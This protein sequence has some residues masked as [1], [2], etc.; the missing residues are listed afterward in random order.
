MNVRQNILNLIGLNS[1]SIKCIT[2][3]L[4]NVQRV[5]DNGM[6]RIIITKELIINLPI[7]FTP[8]DWRNFRISIGYDANIVVGTMWL[9]DG[10]IA[11]IDYDSDNL[12]KQDGF[13]LLNIPTFPFE[14]LDHSKDSADIEAF[15]WGDSKKK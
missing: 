11:T 13:K 1:N 4:S 7:N 6:P 12:N 8:L 15:E 14:L 5:L 9:E 10:E 2:L 3:K